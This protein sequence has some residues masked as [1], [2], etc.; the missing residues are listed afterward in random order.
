M[1]VINHTIGESVIVNEIRQS[2]TLIFGSSGVSWNATL[3]IVLNMVLEIQH[4][5]SE[6]F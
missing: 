2:V 3:F 5:C 6:H 1:L 4:S